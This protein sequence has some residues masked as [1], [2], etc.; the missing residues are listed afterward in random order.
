MAYVPHG[1]RHRKVSHPVQE[2][3]RTRSLLRA[4]IRLLLWTAWQEVRTHVAQ[5][6]RDHL[7]WWPFQ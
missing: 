7:G 5:W 4:G 1:K 2:E 6:L 3:S